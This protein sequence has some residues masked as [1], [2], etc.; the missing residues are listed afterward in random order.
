MSSLPYDIIAQFIDT[1]GENNETNLLKELA[2]V[3]H[4]FHQICSKHLFA[5]VELHDADPG[6]DIGSSKKGFVKLLTSRPDVVKHIRNLTYKVKIE[7]DRP[8]T[9]DHLPPIL[10]N[11]LRTIPGLNYLKIS[12]SSSSWFDWNNL[13]SSLRLALLHLIHLPTI[14][15]IDLSFIQNF[16]LSSLTPSVNLHRLDI[17]RLKCTD[18]PEEVVV[19]S[20]MM[21]NIRE[22]HIRDS[23][24]MTTRLLHA[25]MQDGQPAFKF[26]DLRGLY[27]CLEDKQNVRYLV[28]NAKLLEKLHL[29]VRYGQSLVELHDI[30]SPRAYT[31][32]VL[33]LTGTLTEL[34]Y[35]SVHQPF[36]RLWEELE[37]MAGHN[38]LEALTFEVYV[39]FRDSENSIAS[40][41]RNVEKVLVKPG[42]PALRKVSF[43][44]VGDSAGLSEA[45]QSLP[46]KHLSHLLKLDSVAFRYS[47]YVT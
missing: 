26:M 46:D 45:L 32:K 36:Q 30:L 29:T 40:M 38:M 43:K 8:P 34:L 19:Q 10:P 14:N 20:E 2:L 21:P 18:P 15:H 16:P 7:C 23:S 42:W 6:N 5:T 4:C 3:S 17:W 22:F 35:V 28:R 41:I 27:T 9:D 11:L 44:V 31:L 39:G 25:K 37:A 1:V 13:E 24:L 47:V 12:T 33:T